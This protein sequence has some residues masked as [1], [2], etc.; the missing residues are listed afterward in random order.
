MSE[1]IKTQILLNKDWDI[2]YFL[3]AAE[4]EMSANGAS[5]SINLSAYFD[6]QGVT[7]PANTQM[8]FQ[9]VIPRLSIIN[10][11]VERNYRAMPQFLITGIETAA[12]L[13]SLQEYAVN[14]MTVSK[15]NAGFVAAAAGF[16][17]QTI[18]YSPAID[19]DKIYSVYKA[20]N[21]M[22]SRSVII[23]FVYKPLY[24]IEEITNSQKRTFVKS[25]TAIELCRPDAVGVVTVS[26]M[27]DLFGT[28]ASTSTT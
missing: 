11:V 6:S 26:G 13:E 2:A 21:D 24:I 9:A 10:R 27:T 14:M 17:N 8:I 25:R 23:D 15:G 28:V 12:L 5:Q 18:L 4:S 22:L 3:S 20:P 7:S 1:V 16:R 19:N